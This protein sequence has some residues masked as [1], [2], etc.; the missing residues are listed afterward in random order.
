MK[1][2]TKRGVVYHATPNPAKCFLAKS[3]VLSNKLNRG[4]ITQSELLE[5]AEFRSKRSPISVTGKMSVDIPVVDIPVSKE[6]FKT[7]TIWGKEMQVTIEE[8]NK[9]VAHLTL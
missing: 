9:H 5:L 4:T 2:T 7:I 6:K 8:Y 3:E 1:K